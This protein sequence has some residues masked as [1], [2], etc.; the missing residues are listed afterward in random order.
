MSVSGNPAVP[1]GPT[2]TEN[3]TERSRMPATRP[4]HLAAEIG[5][6]PRYDAASHVALARLAE[7][8]A[9]DFV[10]LRDSFARPGLDAAAVLA[11]VAP[12]TARVG[13]VPTLTTTHT[14]PFHVSSAVATLDWVSR[15]RAGWHADVSTTE[16][17]ARLFGRRPAAPAP[18]LWQEA[19]EVADVVARLWDSWEDDAEIR[20]VATGR[21]VDRDKLHHI[22]FEGSTFS[23]KGPAIVPRPPQGRPVTVI[24]A[25]TAPAGRVAARHADVVYVRASSPEQAAALRAEVHRSAARHGRDPQAVRV[26]VALTVDLGDAETAPEPGLESGPQLAGHG[27]YFRGGPVDLAELITQWYRAGAVDGFHLTP[28]S[29]ARDL[30]RIVNGTVALLQHRSLFRTFYPGGTLREHL[31]L[32]RPANR[33]AA[34]RTEAAS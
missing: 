7:G 30:E 28:L 27:T 2:G 15:G 9:L 3:R 22:D 33:Y 29:P 26:L 11:R 19:G 1:D 23:V 6:P 24:D 4:L 21:F 20:S 14:E 17:E 18:A 5:G 16:A 34:P 13:L 32:T 31:G 12:E 8:G 25:T 10:T